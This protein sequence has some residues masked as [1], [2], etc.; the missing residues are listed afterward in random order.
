MNKPLDYEEVLCRNVRTTTLCNWE[1]RLLPRSL[2]FGNGNSEAGARVVHVLRITF[3]QDVR[4]EAHD[5]TLRCRV[6]LVVDR[7]L[8]KA[9]STPRRALVAFDNRSVNGGIRTRFADFPLHR[10][11]VPRA[12]LLCRIVGP[13]FA[14]GLR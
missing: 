12:I 5:P 2:K 13:T 3:P 8:V 11:H 7:A 1:K 14:L 6:F 4:I 10:R 9:P